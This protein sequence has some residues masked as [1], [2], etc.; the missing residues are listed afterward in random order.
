MLRPHLIIK[1]LVE[2]TSFF[3]TMCITQTDAAGSCAVAALAQK[4]V[5]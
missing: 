5:T 3:V 1:D 2:G 4:L